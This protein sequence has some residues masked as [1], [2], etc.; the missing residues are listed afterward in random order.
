[1][2]VMSILPM[3]AMIQTASAGCGPEETTPL[4][5]TLVLRG[6]TYRLIGVCGW[7]VYR[8]KTTDSTFLDRAETDHVVVL[9][10][11][12]SVDPTTTEEAWPAPAG[13]L[14]LSYPFPHDEAAARAVIEAAIEGWRLAHIPDVSLT[15]GWDGPYGGHRVDDGRFLTGIALQPHRHFT[16]IGLDLHL[17]ATPEQYADDVLALIH[18]LADR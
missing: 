1:M 13:N 3:L 18:T 15:A 16:Q 2:P 5:D 10:T 12:E 14:Y 17:N 8:T 11:E 9:V 6:H 4:P 7:P